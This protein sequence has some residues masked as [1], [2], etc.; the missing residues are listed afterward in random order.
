MDGNAVALTHKRRRITD[1]GGED[2]CAVSA[3]YMLSFPRVEEE[4]ARSVNAGRRREGDVSAL[5]C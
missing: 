2:N 4:E 5:W 3:V 1:V